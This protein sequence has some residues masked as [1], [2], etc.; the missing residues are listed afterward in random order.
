MEVIDSGSFRYQKNWLRKD[1]R[2][3]DIIPRNHVRKVSTGDDGSSVIGTV[4]ATCSTGELPE[5]S[6]ASNREDDDEGWCGASWMVVLLVTAR[7]EID[8][9]DI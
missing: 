4:S 9:E 7:L 8:R 2:M 3:Q 6:W 5:I 1:R